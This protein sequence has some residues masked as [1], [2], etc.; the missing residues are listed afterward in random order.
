VR[1]RTQIITDAC[2][3]DYFPFLE[4]V[5][6]VAVDCRNY[7]VHGANDSDL[8]VSDVFR[9]MGFLTDTLEFVFYASQPVEFGWNLDVFL[10]RGTTMTHRFGEYKVNYRE[11]WKELEAARKK[12]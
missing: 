2:K 6:S 1:H 11:G 12:S 4:M 8:E 10:K 5:C 7:F 3:A 9:L